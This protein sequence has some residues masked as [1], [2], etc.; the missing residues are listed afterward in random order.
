M[1]LQ[2]LAPRLA[3]INT[4][5]VKVLDVKAGATE[6]PSGRAWMATR[7]RV[8]LEHGYLCASC[9]LIWRSHLDQIDH[10]VPREQGGSND[11][12]NLRPLCDDCHKVK[13]KAEARVRAGG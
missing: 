5:R 13:S 8:A 6:M 9:G 7:Q 10:H 2:R 11:D 4:S 3:T 1:K 12:A